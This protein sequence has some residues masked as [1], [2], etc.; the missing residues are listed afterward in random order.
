M[1]AEGRLLFHI[2]EFERKLDLATKKSADAAAQVKR[3][4]RGMGE[5]L[6]DGFKSA[7]IGGLGA[8]GIGLGVTELLS[9]MKGATEEAQRL[10]NIGQS[11]D[12]PVEAL[13]RL[14][15]AAGKLGVDFE[16]A[17]EFSR[18]LEDKLGDLGN[19]EPMEVLERMGLN[20]QE[21]I[22]MP[23]DDK[24]LT[25]AEAF[26]KSRAEGVGYSD[27]L[28]LVGD[29]AGEQLLPILTQTKESL[30]E[31]FSEAPVMADE[32]IDRMAEL[33]GEFDA[34]VMKS[35]A[36]FAESVAGITGLAQFAGDFLSTASL[37]EAMMMAAEREEESYA[38][39]FR[40]EDMGKAKAEAIEVARAAEA[41]AEA[42][43][44]SAKA[45]E[46]AAEE[47]AKI[48]D[49]IAKNDFQLLPDEEKVAA[50][51]QQ[52]DQLL[53]DSVGLFSLNFE[54]TIEGL[55][56]LAKDREAQGDRLPE[57][58]VN[59]A[60]EAFD[61]LREAKQLAA[62]RAQLEKQM[63]DKEAA[64][65]EKRAKELETLREKAGEGEFQMLDPEEQAKRLTEQLGES[66]GFD[67]SGVED[68][69][70]GLKQARDEV[71]AARAAGDEAAEKAALENL[72]DAQGKARDLA[73][74]TGSAEDEESPLV[75]GRGTVAGAIANLFNRSSADLQLDESKVQTGI[76]SRIAGILDDIHKAD[77]PD[78]FTDP[79]V[80][81]P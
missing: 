31:V 13:Q 53:K 60:A 40:S 27:L 6:S 75:N 55:E 66:F 23:I 5:S 1:A 39:R 7:A 52:L 61:W 70:R 25:I 34:M 48:K 50:L 19:S 9:S 43:E 76:L 69:E 49:A 63:A 10:R 62:D 16:T 21:L 8:V 18:E 80:T 74:I 81:Y 57:S 20:A 4:T 14:Q 77:L 54:T 36:W 72:I 64:A 78:P 65:A 22:A 73:A 35:K 28:K 59:S 46:K 47:L 42:R 29:S 33:N 51:K 67:I 71:E 17:T 3:E 58:G 26:Q 56:K 38:N 79:P 24:I 68:V 15:F 45:S 12:E 11:L 37:E 2:A 41:E 30:E 44:R 32:M